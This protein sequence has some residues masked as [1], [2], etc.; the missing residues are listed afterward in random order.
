[1]K[2][3][4][5]EIRTGVNRETIRVYLRNGLVP[6][7][8]RPKPN[9]ADYGEDHVR[10]ITAVR[11]LQRDN[12]LTLRQIKDV[13]RGNLVERQIEAGAYQNLEELVA[14]RMG[15]A[16]RPVLLANLT[17]KLP[18]AE[19]DAYEMA[20][21]GILNIVETKAGPALSVTDA[22]LVTIWSEMRRVGFTDELGFV[23]G[24]LDYY[25]NPARTI[26]EEEASRFI[27]YTEGKITEEQAADMLQQAL[28]LML[29]FFGLI[30]MKAFLERIHRD[31]PS[32]QPRAK[33][34]K[35]PPRYAG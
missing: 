4:D 21:K 17:K 10:A 5:L 15:Q 31:K 33:K 12:G 26:A 13:L 29:D 3:R 20:R 18:K 2:M 28:K 11:E 14:A 6:E 32:A 9:V 8:D 16:G 7:P 30:R 34:A 22:R 27:A 25:V 24:I 23:P 35:G 1:M 19:H